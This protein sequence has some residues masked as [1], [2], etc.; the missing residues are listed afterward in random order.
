MRAMSATDAIAECQFGRRAIR[1]VATGPA[2]P[3]RYAAR[4][5]AVLVRHGPL[6]ARA[7]LSVMPMRGNRTVKAAL[8]RR[9]RVEAI[10]IRRAALM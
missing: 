7:T 2:R 6:A 9:F 5:A 8:V 3:R 4:A 10:G 1:V